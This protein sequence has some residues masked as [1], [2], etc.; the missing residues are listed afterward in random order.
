MYTD[1][2]VDEMKQ[3]DGFLMKNARPSA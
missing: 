2:V 3:D 1:E